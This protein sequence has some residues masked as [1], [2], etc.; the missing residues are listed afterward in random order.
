MN[1]ELQSSLNFDGETYDP[2]LD[3]HRLSSQFRRVLALMEDGKWRSLTE[4]RAALGDKDSEAAIS[5]RL[6]DFRNKHRMTVERHRRTP[7][8]FEYKVTKC[9]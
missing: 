7:G 8:L 1:P 5:A 2:T 4:I 3:K 6:R 9:Q